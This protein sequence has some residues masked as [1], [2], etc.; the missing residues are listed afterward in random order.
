MSGLAGIDFKG[1]A[2]LTAMAIGLAVAYKIYSERKSLGDAADEIADR[3]AEAADAV[4]P[5]SPNNIAYKAANSA[6]RVFTG[7]EEATLGT[8][9]AEW[10]NPDVKRADAEI[11]AAVTGAGKPAVDWE[12]ELASA[13]EGLAADSAKQNEFYRR[14]GPSA[15]SLM[16]AR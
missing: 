12:S 10:F 7:D 2:Y 1:L 8:K 5:V 16:L 15:A 13:W 6:L 11:A 3:V 9:I 4:N 14:M